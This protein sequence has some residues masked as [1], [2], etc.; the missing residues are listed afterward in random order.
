MPTVTLFFWGGYAHPLPPSHPL[1]CSRRPF[2]LSLTAQIPL[3]STRRVEPLP[4]RLAWTR[5]IC[6]CLSTTRWRCGRSPLNCRS[7]ARNAWTGSTARTSLPTN[8]RGSLV[9]SPKPR[10]STVWIPVHSGPMSTKTARAECRTRNV[11]IP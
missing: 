3:F 7:R 10:A 11:S 5:R 1:S 6:R 2:P 9:S 8:W 4:A